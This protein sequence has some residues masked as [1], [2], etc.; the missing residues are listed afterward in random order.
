MAILAVVLAAL[1]V[2]YGS[3]RSSIGT[4]RSAPSLAG[5][6]FYYNYAAKHEVGQFRDFVITLEG[7]PKRLSFQHGVTFLSIIPGAPF[8]TSS[9]LFSTTFFP[10]LF[11][12]GTG[13][14]TP[15]PG[16]LFMNFGFW[17]VLLGMALF[18]A[19][20]GLIEAHHRRN[21]GS[22]MA[23][24]IYAY[25]LV[26]MAGVL[27]GSFTTFAGFF[28][29]GLIPILLLRPLIEPAAVTAMGDDRESQP[30]RRATAS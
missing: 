10:K 12:K 9:Y 15:L 7:V 17:G 4:R 25:S 13:I 3:E 18:G 8:P 26:P 6:N 23:L 28:I 2:A 5:S 21:P 24:L 1:F 27:R 22:I 30:E 19:A 20:L 14:P 11:A 29:L 16:E